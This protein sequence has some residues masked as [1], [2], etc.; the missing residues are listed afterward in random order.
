MISTDKLKEILDFR[1]QLFK[2]YRTG[3]ISAS[4]FANRSFN[5]FTQYKFKFVKKA[6]DLPSVV[7]NY[8]YWTSKIERRI[9]VERELAQY[10]CSDE[11]QLAQLLSLFVKRRNQMF[12]R[13]LYEFGKDDVSPEDQEKGNYIEV[14]SAFIVIEDLVEVKL[15]GYDHIFYC[16]KEV[17][18]RLKIKILQ[19][20][21]S[22]QSYYLPFI[23]YKIN[24]IK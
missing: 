9:Y 21:Q 24:H 20:G 10:G 4:T 8:L 6:H 2:D 17:L 1:S 15:K 18:D 5:H 14:E 23:H 22:S 3:K 11:N 12:R 13:L 16:N 19:Y 7:F